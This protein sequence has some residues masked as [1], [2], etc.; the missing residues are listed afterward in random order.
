VQGTKFFIS[1]LCI[2]FVYST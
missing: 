1:L 2:S